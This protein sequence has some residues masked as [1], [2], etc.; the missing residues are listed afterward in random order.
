MHFLGVAG[1]PRRIPDYPDSFFYFNFISSWG[2]VLSFFSLIVFFLL[3]LDS[4]IDKKK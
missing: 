3:I 1:M 2:S 4:F